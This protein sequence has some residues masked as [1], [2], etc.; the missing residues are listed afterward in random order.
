MCQQDSLVAAGHAHMGD[1]LSWQETLV[2]RGYFNFLETWTR[3]GSWSQLD[4]SRFQR[5]RIHLEMEFI[6]F[7]L[8]KQQF[9]LRGF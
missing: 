5:L 6:S 8:F 9:W 4:Q 7:S 3:I 1:H 2:N